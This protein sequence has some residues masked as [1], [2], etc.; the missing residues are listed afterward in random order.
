MKTVSYAA[1]VLALSALGCTTQTIPGPLVVSTRQV[2]ELGT[3]GADAKPVVGESC[4]RVVLLVIPVGFAT[5]ESAYADALSQAPGSDTVVDIEQRTTN[6]FIFPF[7]YQICTEFHGYAVSS[8][9]RTSAAEP[10]P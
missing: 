2:P 9:S 3:R 1:V 5:A 6:L 8:K 4:G 7:Y 10:A